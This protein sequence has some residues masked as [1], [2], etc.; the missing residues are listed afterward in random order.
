MLINA[1]S[2]SVFMTSSG[3]DY[4]WT[5]LKVIQECI[6]SKPVIFVTVR[7]QRMHS[8]R[9]AG[10]CFLSAKVIFYSICCQKKLG[11]NFILCIESNFPQL[12]LVSRTLLTEAPEESK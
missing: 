8:S 7:V 1:C 5:N 3:S 12:T 9:L 10:S 4:S 11:K 2:C 6:T